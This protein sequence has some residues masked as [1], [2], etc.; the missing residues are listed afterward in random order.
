[1][2]VHHMG[3]H[4]LRHIESLRPK[5]NLVHLP[6]VRGN[7][8]AQRNPTWALGERAKLQTVA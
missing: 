3:A 1:M 7:R 2:A 4:K 8:N 5:G 6:K